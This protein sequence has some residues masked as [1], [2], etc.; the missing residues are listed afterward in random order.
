MKENF[1]TR[2][3]VSHSDNRKSKTCGE[4][5]R[6]IQNLK[7]VGL[8]SLAFVLVS[9]AAVVEAQQPKKFYRIGY[10]SNTSPSAES[11]RVEAIGKQ[12]RQLGYVEGQN[13]SIDYRY[14]EGN[15]ERSPKL[16]AELVALNCDVIVVY[17]GQFWVRAVMAA[18]KTIPIVMAGG[19]LDPVDTGLIK[20]LAR[21]GGNVTG[22]IT[23]A[24]N[25]AS[26]RLDI[27]KEALPKL[28]RIA[29]LYDPAIPASQ[30]VLKNGLPDSARA[31]K[32]TLQPR[33]VNTTEDFEK[34]FA[35]MGK[36][37]LD[38]VFIAGGGGLFFAN[39][40]RIAD[41]A[42]KSRLP[43]MFARKF[44][45]EAGG[46]MSYSADTEESYRQ[47]VW[48]IDKILKGTKPADLPAQQPMKFEFVVNLQTAKKIGVTINTDVLARATKIIR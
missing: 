41:F 44:E 3:E 42:V 16:A 17:G 11:T 21:P 20:S 40:K 38:G 47:V 34:V 5:S 28:I 29:V 19:G 18:T 10:L 27:F 2:S 15:L 33:E 22:I 12:L 30:Y 48:Y 32:L 6:T 37:R 26:K 7:S 24:S 13:V 35:A 45:V 9:L 39:G 31:L 4:R 23:L 14:G 46:L 36:Q 1:C 25:L 8:F 43:S